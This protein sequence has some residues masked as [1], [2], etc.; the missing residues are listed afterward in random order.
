LHIFPV[1]AGPTVQKGVIAAAAALNVE[2]LKFTLSP[3]D[4]C[5][6]RK[7]MRPVVSAGFQTAFSATV[8][9]AMIKSVNRVMRDARAAVKALKRWRRAPSSVF[10]L[11]LSIYL[12]FGTQPLF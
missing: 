11:S 9:V 2:V 8:G 7:S 4:L 1:L 3:S 12:V 6:I 10:I 5:S